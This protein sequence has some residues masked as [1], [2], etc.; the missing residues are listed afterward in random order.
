[1]KNDLWMTLCTPPYAELTC[2]IAST[3]VS[4]FGFNNGYSFL[5]SCNKGQSN[6]ARHV[7]SWH[8]NA[9]SE[10]RQAGT[11]YSTRRAESTSMMAGLQYEG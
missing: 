8:T 9:M 10:G 4:T 7:T 3:N 5:R 2:N 6:R 1:M 11:V